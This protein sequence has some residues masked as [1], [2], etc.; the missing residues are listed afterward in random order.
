MLSGFFKDTDAYGTANVW[1]WCKNSDVYCGT[2]EGCAPGT[3][4]GQCKGV[5]WDKLEPDHNITVKFDDHPSGT[6]MTIM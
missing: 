6:G 3:T 2:V 1:Q 4:P 5:Q